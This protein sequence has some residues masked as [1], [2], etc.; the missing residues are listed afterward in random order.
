MT[1]H[2]D[3]VVCC[4]IL[5][6][7]TTDCPA[8]NETVSLRSAYGLSLP[9]KPAIEARLLYMERTTS[10]AHNGTKRLFGFRKARWAVILGTFTLLARAQQS[11]P[12]VLTLED[13]IQQAVQN[14]SSLK[15]ASL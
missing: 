8:L 11:S 2:D 4:K 12:P 13:A 7:R 14:N 10:I 6:V 9:P 3:V 1:I 15:T 5:Q